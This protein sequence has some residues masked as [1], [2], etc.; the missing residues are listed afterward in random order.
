MMGNMGQDGCT[1]RFMDWIEP[2]CSFYSKDIIEDI[3]EYL[4]TKKRN[5]HDLLKDLNFSYVEEDI[6]RAYSP[7]W[8][9]FLNLNTKEDLDNYLGF[10]GEEVGS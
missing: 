6:A 5:I 1:T 3:E 9:M 10:I 4:K 8:D 2:F 7:N